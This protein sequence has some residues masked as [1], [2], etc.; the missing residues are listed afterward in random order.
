LL[1]SATGAVKSIYDKELSREMVDADANDGVNQFV[2]RWVQT[3]KLEGPREATI[4]EGQKGPVYG[5]IVARSEGAGGPQITQEVILYD[6]IK[7]IDFANRVLKDST[8]LLEIY[9]AFPFKIDDPAILF[10]GSN[11]VIKPLRDQFPG[12][13]SNYYSVQH[14]AEVSEGEVGVTLSAV[15]SHLMEFGGLWPCYVSQAH[16]GFTPPGFG[17]EF[18]KA[19][20]ITK[21]HIYSF[22]MD[23][24]F[25]TNFQPVQQGDMLFRYSVATHKGEW[26]D[27]RR[28]FGWA[29]GNPLIPA[30]VEG[31][32]D[33]TLE[34]KASFCSVSEGNVMLLT[35]KRAEDG[36]GVIIR[37][38]ETDGRDGDVRVSLPFLTMKNAYATSLVE[39]DKGGLVCAGHSFMT[40]MKAYGI[41]TIRVQGD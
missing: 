18:V 34:R 2:A 4:Q 29:A 31:K 35:L 16:H 1:D 7:R 5:S 23:G 10:E 41:R 24:N 6:R 13:N 12:S 28:N 27:G 3:G 19:G 9:F 40:P 20:D 21:G 14:W 8:P 26:K 25:R 17:A 15:E 37:L 30:V 22:V 11:S 33:G 39:E 32:R 38:I 36:K